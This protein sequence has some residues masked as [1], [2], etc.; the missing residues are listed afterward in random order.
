LDGS[1]DCEQYDAAVSALREQLSAYPAGEPETSLAV[2]LADALA[3]R[4]GCRM[5]IGDT[6]GARAD[7]D[8]TVQLLDTVLTRIS[9]VHPLYETT[10]LAAAA[11]HEERWTTSGDPADRDETI[12]QLSAYLDAMTA[13]GRTAASGD[14]LLPETGPGPA[15][16]HAA[17][18]RLLGGR[19]EDAGPGDQAIAERAAADLEAAI[20][21]AQAGLRCYGRAADARGGQFTGGQQETIG[22]E[23]TDTV[24][25]LRA[26]L[27][28]A[29][30]YRFAEREQAI[31]DGHGADDRAVGA[32]L[33]DARADRDEAITVLAA[34]RRSWTADQV[35]S[36]IA[37]T[38]GQLYR[39]RYKGQPPGVTADRGDL[40]DAIELL[41]GAA[42]QAEP[43]PQIVESLFLSL[44]DRAELS[45]S[46]ADR[47][48]SI[49]WGQVLLGIVG[50]TDDSAPALHSMLG[51]ALLDRAEDSP[52]TRAADL[53]AAI[54]HLEAERAASPPGDPGRAGQVAILAD[55]CWKRLDGD[56]TDYAAV[57]RMTGYAAE[58]WQLLPTEDESSP[59]AGFYFAIGLHERLRRP[60]EPFDLDAANLAVGV[61][62][63]IEPLEADPD[64]HVIVVTILSMFLVSRAQFLGSADEFAAAQPWIMMAVRELPADDS[65]MSELAQTLAVALSTLAVLGMSADNLDKAIELLTVVTGRPSAEPARD[66]QTRNMLGTVLVQRAGFTAS[67][68][69]LEA[70]IAH[71]RASWDMTSPGS[72]DRIRFAA[73]LCSALMQRFSQRGDAQDLD[74][75]EFYLEA[76]RALSSNH[77]EAYVSDTSD[78]DVML[79]A[80]HGTLRTLRG[81]ADH[82]KAALDEGVQGLRDALVALPAGHPYHG[83]IR[84]D[85]GLALMMRV[86]FGERR[87]TDLQEA[88]GEI[89]AAVTTMPG[90]HVMRPLALMRTAAAMAAAAQTAGDA[91]MLSEAIRNLTDMRGGLDPRFGEGVRCTAVLG[92]A[93][94][95]MYR[96]TGDAAEIDAAIEWLEQARRELEGRP[97]HPQRG[98]ILME[99]A[100]HYR[101]RSGTAPHR[102]PAPGG[103]A[104]TSRAAGL[105][106]LRE[107]GRDV[108]LQTG[109]ARGLGFASVAAAE[110]VEVTGWCL[111]DGEAEAAVAALELGRSLILHAAT[112][113]TGVPE[114]LARAGRDD[115]AGEWRAATAA[116]PTAPWD[117]ETRAADFG[118][119]LL[120][121]NAP[122][123]MPA[124]LRARALAALSGSGTENET[125][126]GKL[127]APPSCADIAAALSE[128]GADALVYLLDP[129]NTSAGR[130]IVIRAGSGPDSAAEMLPL[131]L[132][133]RGTA[134]PLAD[135][136]A[137]YTTL[138]ASAE[139]DGDGGE[140]AS[141]T[142]A[143]E[144]WRAALGQLCDWAWP[145]AMSP[146]LQR[147]AQ[148][149]L[150]RPPRLVLV[151]VGRLSLVPWHAARRGADLPG[152]ERYACSAAVISYAASGRQLIEVSGRPA[153]A[154]QASPVIVGNPAMN[155]TI[156]GLEAQAIRDRCYPAGS[157]LG[158]A[159][160]TWGQQADGPGLPDELLGQLPAAGRPGA[161]LLH[162]GCHARLVAAAPGQSYLQ[163]A[164]DKELT[165]EAILRQASGRPPLAPGGLVSVAACASDY[166]GAVYDEA[167]TLAT[168]FL[169][170]G[171]VTVAGARWEIGEG[172][173]SLLMFMFHHFMTTGGQ[174]PRD[175]LRLAQLWMLDPDRA[176]PTQM[177]DQLAGWLKTLDAQDVAGWAAFT[178]QGR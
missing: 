84:S 4:Y 130:A 123:E 63:Q 3:D 23:E 148:W 118:T 59:L 83:R 56:A 117:G 12:R 78:A 167:L 163:L 166:G 72:V 112:A 106:A 53:D 48:A 49:R 160:A 157:Y 50:E 97:D 32:A 133:H 75:A 161:S 15:D 29:L 24:A 169:A 178:H 74:A 105:A 120:A 60:G 71:L 134:G 81:F 68:R 104:A 31:P 86:G 28:L 121:G 119:D 93:H 25:D 26:I 92:A 132:L 131:P 9:L 33:C 66:A 176:A 146:V 35:K 135:Y 79:A 38:L 113:V 7:L 153:L 170:A 2:E 94:M 77:H 19:Y 22:Q 136:A 175:A 150:G 127:L 165:I 54:G 91:R 125:G 100:R 139:A 18:A 101:A 122:L 62:T 154:L 171:A 174:S 88:L 14:E 70:G 159:A 43:A 138:T 61:L 96:L 64:V 103:D 115:L 140:P 11:A 69:D 5:E 58:A 82:D 151:P 21:H 13:F 1:A 6:D 109:T 16:L 168:A 41:S 141:S 73:N 99:L 145:T 85:L 114:M 142:L 156:A 108:L 8:E 36:G 89:G 107:R 40:D 67:E 162:L 30:A 158:F 137:A 172:M 20:G 55:A 155:L 129:A 147:A 116:T 111:E 177:P 152:P 44:W 173:T 126:A 42:E 47:D 102:D 124:D 10:A 52:G 143:I 164:D 17:L 39:D 76:A 149:G 128:T 65:Q 87:P 57:D 45:D 110:A 51:L 98:N 90:D 80:M 37:A 34:V 27:G 144:R 46:A 95:A